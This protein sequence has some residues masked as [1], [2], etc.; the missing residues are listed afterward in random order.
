MIKLIIF[1][2]DGVLIESK[3]LHYE[4]LNRALV[5]FNETPISYKEHI[6]LFDGKPTKEKLKIRKV[7]EYKHALINDRKQVYTSELLEATVKPVEKFIELFERLKKE[8]LIIQVASNSIRLTVST[9]LSKM[10]LIQKVQSFIS[11]E[12]V[13]EGK[14]SPEMY[15]RGMLNAGVGPRETLIIEDS[16]VGRSAV[17]N[18]GAHLCAVTDPSEVTYDLIK[19]SINKFSGIKQKWVS[20]GMN[21]VIPMAGAGSRFVNAGYT[22][23]KPLI[24]V[25]GKPMIQVVVESLN[26]EGHFIYLVRREHY[27]KYNLKCML[28]MLT[29]GCSIVIV[30]NLTEGA[31]C[32]VLLAKALINNDQQL[33]IVNSDQYIEWNS[34]HFMYAMQS[35]HIDGGVLTFKNNHP[36]WS[37][38]KADGHDIIQEIKEK[39][40]ISN[41]A[42]VGIYHWKRGSDFI[43]YSEQMI[44]NNNRVNNEFYVAPVYNEAIRDGKKFKIYQVD[45]MLGLGTPEDLNYFLSIRS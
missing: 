23:P 9:I 45:K 28:E 26:M 33:L 27:D 25:H 42:T 40:V 43:K 38:A 3:D 20:N 41:D 24:D 29:P 17:F 1:D 32:T 15:L 34:S 10:N 35:T 18:S 11:N 7:S 6:S 2:L 31:C 5:D 37:Y 16:Y 4:A 8:G 22:F 39:A 44:A 36:K 12:D 14:P 30:E 19:A 13:V 21:I